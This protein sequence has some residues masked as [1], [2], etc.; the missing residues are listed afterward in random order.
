[1]RPR[2]TGT[3]LLVTDG[4]ELPVEGADLAQ[5]MGQLYATQAIVHI[6]SYTLLGSKAV[7][8]Q[9]PKIPVLLTGVKRKSA[10]E[11]ILRAN[12]SKCS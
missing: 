1:M 2:I 8:G 3:C 7:D 10:Q 6:V 5:A 9:P 11:T 4:G 12:S